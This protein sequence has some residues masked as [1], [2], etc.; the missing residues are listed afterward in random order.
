MIHP[1][2]PEDPALIRR[3]GREL[4]LKR[5]AVALGVVTL[6]A[7]LAVQAFYAV[8]DHER[9]IRD[10]AQAEQIEKLVRDVNDQAETNYSVSRQVRKVLLGVRSCTT[11]EGECAKAGAQAQLEQTGAVNEVTIVAA[12]CIATTIRSL[13]DLDDQQI[14]EEIRECVVTQTARGD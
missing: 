10:A 2:A 3:R 13:E 11:P 12:V 1:A 8:K 14:E 4:A 6:V 7:I 5:L 9:Q